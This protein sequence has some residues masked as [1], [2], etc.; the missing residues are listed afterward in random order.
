MSSLHAAI[1]NERVCQI[2]V[3]LTVGIKVNTKDEL[4]RTPLMIA[5]FMTNK[6]R[7]EIVCKLLLDHGANVKIR[8]K[9]KRTILMYACATRNEFLL[10][11]LLLYNDDDLNWKDVDGNTCLMY[12]AI[13]GDIKV[14]E[15][16][17]RPF[18]RYGVDLDVSN[19]N[20]LT[21]YL[22]ALR[23]GNRDCANLLQSS[24]ASHHIFDTTNYW[25]GNEWLE[26]HY[27]LRYK[28]E[29]LQYQSQ[30]RAKSQALQRNCDTSSSILQRQFSIPNL[31]SRDINDELEERMIQTEAEQAWNTKTAFATV[32]LDVIA[33]KHK[34]YNAFNTNHGKRKKARKPLVNN[35]KGKTAL[36]ET[37]TPAIQQEK[38]DELHEMQDRA[39]G[40][41]AVFTQ[42]QV[43]ESKFPQALSYAEKRGCH[44]DVLLSVQ[45]QTRRQNDQLMMLFKEYSLNQIPIPP[46]IPQRVCRMK[47][48]R[49]IRRI[50]IEKP[51]KGCSTIIKGKRGTRE[52][53]IEQ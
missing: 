37:E 8:D 50:S 42:Q 14:L 10:D 2:Q 24:G 47:P 13:E 26:F 30:T 40:D 36:K 33:I 52:M 6:R 32:N 34:K 1:F 3:F 53:T 43:H 5:C 44:H 39:I 51:K 15:K 25:H 4:G 23:N 27:M 31:L 12:A 9:F 41:Y 22:L 21:A 35:F 48:F 46:A 29:S 18:I 38:D 45:P 49:L 11:Q 17:L 7:R 28:Q 19:K 16:L 20:G